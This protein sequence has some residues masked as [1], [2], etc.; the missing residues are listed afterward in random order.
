MQRVVALEAL[1]EIHESPAATALAKATFWCGDNLSTTPDKPQVPP[2]PGLAKKGISTSITKS[3]GI[4]DTGWSR[5]DKTNW[6]LRRGIV[7]A[8]GLDPWSDADHRF[9]RY[10]QWALEHRPEPGGSG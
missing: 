5:T 10:M 6:Y 9:D 7:A 8:E 1:P 3:L 4:K 2:P